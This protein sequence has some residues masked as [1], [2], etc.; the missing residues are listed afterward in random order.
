MLRYCTL[1]FFIKAHRY[2]P[3]SGIKRISA[4]VGID[5]KGRKIKQRISQKTLNLTK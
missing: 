1:L 4:T 5:P 2:R 3:T